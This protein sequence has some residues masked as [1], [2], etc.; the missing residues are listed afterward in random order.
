MKTLILEFDLL[1][2][3][4]MCRLTSMI[5]IVLENLNMQVCSHVI[6]YS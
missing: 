1:E 2:V 6:L 3:T 5:A 4:K